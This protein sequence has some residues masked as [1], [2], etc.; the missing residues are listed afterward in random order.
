MRAMRAFV[1]LPTDEPIRDALSRMIERLRRVDA[2]VRWVDPQSLHVTL[3][4]LGWIEDDQLAK[5][6]ELL[7]TDAARFTP[8][9]IEFHGLGQFPPRGIP[10][11]VWAG[12]RGDVEKLAGLAGAVERAAVAIGVEPDTR[13]PFSPHLTIGRVKSSRGARALAEQ[14]AAKADE[15]FGRQ[16]V[17]SIILFKST[18]TPKGPIYETIESFPLGS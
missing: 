10:R 18:L 13:L 17:A 14:I 3:K 2:D 4:F 1:A 5:I 12:C 9:Q 15:P 7:R 8:L 16:T 6:R 11:V